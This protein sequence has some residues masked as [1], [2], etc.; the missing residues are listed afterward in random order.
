ML[1][2]FL[3]RSDDCGTKKIFTCKNFTLVNFLIKDDA[4]T[5][6][7]TESIIIE[8]I[9]LDH[10]LN[11]SVP[12]MAFIVDQYLFSNATVDKKNKSLSHQDIAATCHEV[13]SWCASHAELVDDSFLPFLDFIRNIEYRHHTEF[14][15]NE[16]ISESLFADLEQLYGQM[17][18]YT[19]KSGHVY[20]FPNSENKLCSISSEEMLTI[21]TF[22]MSKDDPNYATS[23]PFLFYQILTTLKKLWFF[24]GDYGN[25]NMSNWTCFWRIISDFC[26]FAQWPDYPGYKNELVMIIKDFQLNTEKKG[27]Y[28][29]EA[30]ILDNRVFLRGKMIKT[31]DDAVVLKSDYRAK[32]DDYTQAYRIVHGPGA[33]ATK[34]PYILLLKKDEV[35]DCDSVM[36][37]LVAK[38]ASDEFPD[39]KDA[40]AVPIL[41]DGMYF[42]Q[43]IKWLTV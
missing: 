43:R 17:I 12:D 16:T 37:D 27:E 39:S 4:A 42:D 41:H 19:E 28:N 3:N 18:K 33:G 24:G 11:T 35:S 14:L 25:A 31:T 30:P 32:D 10:Y 6:N 34:K 23:N 7:T 36:E 8:D 2:D 5:K 40:F 13:A 22:L 38:Y 9:L 20:H 1:F 15:G 29:M 21:R 26:A